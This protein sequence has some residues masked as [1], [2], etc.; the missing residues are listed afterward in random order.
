MAACACPVTTSTRLICEGER[1][2][3]ACQRSSRLV[4]YS[5]HFGPALD[6]M[7]R[8]TLPAANCRRPAPQSDPASWPPADKRE[9]APPP[10][11]PLCALIPV[12]DTIIRACHGRKRCALEASRRVL[13]AGLLS[14]NTSCHQKDDELISGRAFGRALQRANR[15]KVQYTCAPKSI[16]QEQLRL[17]AAEEQ[18]DNSGDSVE[19]T[20]RPAASM[21]PASSVIHRTPK[22]RA[23]SDERERRVAFRPSSRQNAADAAGGGATGAVANNNNSNCTTYLT[24]PSPEPRSLGIFGDWLS[25]YVFI[26]RKL[27]T[28]RKERSR[29]KKSPENSCA[30]CLAAPNTPANIVSLTNHSVWFLSTQE[31][32]N[33]W[34][35]TF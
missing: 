18:I 9:E 1:L 32:S 5:A 12:T 2:E 34:R 3:L 24:Q 33:G 15:L 23:G 17:D 11:Q 6:T 29:K 35:F 26:T 28:S 16:F 8:S 10:L 7:D 25:A 27:E 22:H 13:G 19:F 14:L 4:V 31:I 30:H 21:P 20:Q